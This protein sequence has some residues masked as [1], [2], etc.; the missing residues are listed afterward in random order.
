MF[1]IALVAHDEKKAEMIEYVH[2]VPLATNR[3]S[4]EILMAYVKLR[5]EGGENNANRSN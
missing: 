4:A 5:L 3:Q 2:N 1:K